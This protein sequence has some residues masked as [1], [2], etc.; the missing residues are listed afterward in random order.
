M[1]ISFVF[2][3][4][5]AELRLWK[6]DTTA[7]IAAAS[8][9]DRIL[10]WSGFRD[11]R[12]FPNIFKSFSTSIFRANTSD[13]GGYLFDQTS[14]CWLLEESTYPGRQIISSTGSPQHVVFVVKFRGL[15]SV[16]R[17]G[18]TLFGVLET[19]EECMRKEI[20][21]RKRGIYT[22]CQVASSSYMSNPSLYFKL[23]SSS[24]NKSFLWHQLNPWNF[25]RL[26]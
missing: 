1:C 6:V 13:K 18:L 16:M 24:T 12:G 15:D 17:M 22:R 3:K 21:S 2:W 11:H 23:L 9:N 25:W 5:R 8:R 10:K 7:L 14:R 4:M 19:S 20:E 26:R